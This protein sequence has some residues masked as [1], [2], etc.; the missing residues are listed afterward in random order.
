MMRR[1]HERRSKNNGFDFAKRAKKWSGR[2]FIMVLPRV[3]ARC[4]RPAAWYARALR[5]SA[6]PRRLSVSLETGRG[7][8]VFKSSSGADLDDWLAAEAEVD[9]RLNE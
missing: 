6:S 7:N 2:P 3:R 1:V 5:R 8:R 9:A 4:A